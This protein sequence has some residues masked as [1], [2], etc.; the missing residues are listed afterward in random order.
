MEAQGGPERL[1][2]GAANR[3]RALVSPPL[4]PLS[5]SPQGCVVSARFRFPPGLATLMGL[6]LRA[7]SFKAQQRLRAVS[8][9]RLCSTLPAEPS[10]TL[11][12]AAPGAGVA[13]DAGEKTSWPLLEPETPRLQV[14]LV[15]LSLLPLKGCPRHGRNS[16]TFARG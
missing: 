12:M 7:W 1:V 4:G 13:A 10:E 16:L 2:Q 14:L 3:L 6:R 9:A 15:F 5:L 11:C 8:L